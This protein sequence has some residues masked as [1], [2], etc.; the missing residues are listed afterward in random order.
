MRKVIKQI[1]E[2]LERRSKTF[3]TLFSFFLL[4]PISALDYVTG[5]DLAVSIFYLVPVSLAAWFCGSREGVMISLWSAFVWFSSDLI[6][7]LVQHEHLTTWD[8]GVR[9]AYFL[10]FAYVSYI[11]SSLKMASEREVQNA[12]KDYLTGISNRFNF[13]EQAVL[14]IERARRLKH[15][16]TLAYLDIDNFK[17]VNDKFGHQTG[18]KLLHDAALMIKTQIRGIDVIARMGGDEFAL[19]LP[20][21]GL[22]GAKV[23]LERIRESFMRFMKAEGW[24]CTL[25]AGSVTY[26]VPPRNAD[27]MIRA[28]DRLMYEMKKSGKNTVKFQLVEEG[29]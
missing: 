21:T 5:R 29:V 26:L 19:L 27:Q 25:S 1:R 23:V 28:A 9:I 4:F 13:M 6:W 24:F 14:E 12:R 3:I 7:V 17:V 2:A 11:L 15:P 20:H 10:I 22:E 8:T 18:D 16:I